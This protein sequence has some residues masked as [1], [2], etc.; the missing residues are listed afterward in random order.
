MPRLRFVI[1][2]LVLLGGVAWQVNGL[3]SGPSNP[4]SA[5]HDNGL[6]ASSATAPLATAQAAEILTPRSDAD[7]PAAPAAPVPA[8]P[9]PAPP[10]AAPPPAALPPAEAAVPA[11]P[12]DQAARP[13]VDETALRYFAREGDTRRLNTEIARLRSLY[14][15]WVPPDDPLKAAPIV[16][17]QL[18]ALWQLYSQGQFAAAHAA[19]VARQGKEPGWTPPKDLLD[20]LAVAETRERLVN[21]SNAKQNMT[22][23]ELATVTPSLLTCGDVDVLWRV[24]EAFAQTDRLVRAQDAY[25]YIL[26]ACTDPHDRLSTMQKAMTQ[27]PRAEL[28][29][30]LALGHTG[31]DGD[32]FHSIREGLA[33]NAVVAAVNDNKASADPADLKLLADIAK[34]DGAPADALLLGGYFRG[35]NDPAQAEQWYRLA[36][37]RQN[38]ALAAEGLALAL[39]GLKRSGEAEAILAPW[40]D[41]NDGA[42]KSYMAAIANLLAQ[43]PPPMLAPDVL[44][45]V[46]AAVAAQR[47]PASAQQ[48]GWYAHFYRQ[49]ETAARWFTTALSW[50]P[51]DEPSAYGLAIANLAMNRRDIVRSLVNAWG[52][53]SPRIRAL[54]DPALARELALAGAQSNQAYPAPWMPGM[55]QSPQPS[56]SPQAASAPSILPA[57]MPQQPVAIGTTP[58]VIPPSLPQGTP[59]PQP[60]AM[61]PPVAPAQAIAT[62]PS[63]TME[64]APVRSTSRQRQRPAAPMAATSS[65]RGGCAGGLAGGWCLMKLDRPSEAVIAFQN[66]L[67]SGSAQQRQDAAYGL[68]LAYLRLG[69]TSQAA[70]ASTQASQPT[71]R[72][73]ELNL[74]ILTQR[75]LSDYQGGRYSEALMGL[76]SRARLAPEQTDLLMVRG[77][78]YF[79]LQRFAEARRVFE[80]VAA[81]GNSAAAGAVEAVREA[82][83]S[84]N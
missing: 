37:Q 49:E 48:L 2:A 15:D 18:D 84:R 32:E 25:R 61:A 46:V 56:P 16:D 73:R 71:G 60:Q 21:A 10:P 20:R 40:H 13:V 77:W 27:L 12:A 11:Q 67:A 47:D 80:A 42:R 30:L 14:P 57:Q 76:D 45:R 41:A 74:S 55:P 54:L 82:T 19:I 34:A 65:G 70:A 59:A 28:E 53:H 81:T 38:S 79:H 8:A 33:R 17:P 44:S 31:S 22:V 5:R 68:S 63:A 72:A 1:P 78:S 6:P 29:P 39:I 24:A 50:K 62:P 58:A 4:L 66:A 69:L 36:Y 51:D 23:I 75:I 43:Q 35:H 83:R 3:W 9:K 26:T 52:P 7:A 64:R